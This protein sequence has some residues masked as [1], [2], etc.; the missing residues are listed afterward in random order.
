MRAMKDSGIAW[1]GDV[2][3]QWEAKRNKYNFILSKDIV[4]AKWR[5]MQLLSLTK[6]GI[7]MINDGEQ[8]GTVPT[9]FS[10]YQKV[11]KDDI[12]MCLFDL[13][14]SAVFSGRSGH[15]GMISPAYKCF[16][17]EKHLYPQ[18]ADYYFRTVFVDRKYM[19]YS[20]NVRYSL[21]AEEFLALPILVPPMDE[22][23]RIADFLDRECGK[24]DSIIADVE[25]QI[26]LLKKYKRSVIFEAVT[27]GLEPSVQMKDSGIKWI[28]NIPCNWNV[29]KIKYHLRRNEK[30]NPGNQ[31]VLSVYR[32]YGVIP[33]DSRDDNHNVTSE[34]VSKYKYVRPG[35]LVIN[36]MKAWQ[37]SLAVSDY[38][39]IVSPAYFIFEFMG[40]AFINKYLHYLLR[41]AYKD[42]FRRISGGIREGQWDLSPDEFMNTLV[43]IPPVKEQEKI[44]SYIDKKCAEIDGVIADKKEQLDVLENYK[45]SVIYEYVTGKKEA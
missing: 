32:E 17:C 31:Q 10:T 38:E 21:S 27:K 11:S 5:E 34:D 16:K 18:Y 9:S 29:D 4:G 3:I 37:G 23:K 13:D 42:E 45:K 8:T 44:I 39:G 2:P 7:R 30:R 41:G 1:V 28:G 33:K 12:V 22:Q 25:K 35:S 43:T 26:E 19:R 20:K 14:C 36:K 40:H 15:N 6:Y 24:I